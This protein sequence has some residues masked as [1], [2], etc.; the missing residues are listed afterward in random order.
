MGTPVELAGHHLGG[1]S[2]RT[3]GKKQAAESLVMTSRDP[4]EA[5]KMYLIYWPNST[6]SEALQ[7][8]EKIIDPVVRKK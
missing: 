4:E 8:G 1:S 7:H 5:H 6:F 2:C 3:A